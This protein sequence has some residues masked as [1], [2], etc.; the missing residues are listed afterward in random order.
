MDDIDKGQGGDEPE[1]KL[2]FMQGLE[3]GCVKA[4]GE[5]GGQGVDKEGD[6]LRLLNIQEANQERLR[7]NGGNVIRGE[8]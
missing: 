8:V 3:G 2:G 1:E 4:R 7:G 6:E 5:G